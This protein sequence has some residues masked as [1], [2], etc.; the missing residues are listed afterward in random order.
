LLKELDALKQRDRQLTELDPRFVPAKRQP[1]WERSSEVDS[2][3]R[4]SGGDS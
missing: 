3:I 4:A 2:N 1:S